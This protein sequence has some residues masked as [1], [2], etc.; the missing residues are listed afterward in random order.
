MD[1]LKLDLD[2]DGS[3]D[4]DEFLEVLMKDVRP[5]LHNGLHQHSASINTVLTTHGKHLGAC[6]AELLERRATVGGIPLRCF[7]RMTEFCRSSRPSS[8][9]WTSVMGGSH[10]KLLIYI[11]PITGT[12]P[13]A[14]IPPNTSTSNTCSRPTCT[15]MRTSRYMYLL[16][17]TTHVDR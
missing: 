13:L 8:R 7:Q 15:Y 5:C 6:Y 17:G 16:V 10:Q 12:D 14:R 3:V 4:V 11:L 2:G 9:T 1:K